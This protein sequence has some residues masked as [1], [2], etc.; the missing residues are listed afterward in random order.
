M[1]KTGL[2]GLSTSKGSFISGAIRWFRR[3]FIEGDFIPS[4]AFLT[5]G[6]IHGEIIIAESTDPKLRIYPLCNYVANKNK[7]FELW[8][9]VD[10]DDGLKIEALKKLIRLSGKSYGYKQFLGYA[11][12]TIATKLGLKKPSNPVD[13]EGEIVCSE[14]DFLYLQDIGY[15]EKE[16]MSM[17]KNDV[18]PDN[19]L[20][21]L[22]KSQ[23]AKLRA[24]SEYGTIE[25]KWLE[26]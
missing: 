9:I 12:I 13:D 25:L 2:I 23:R 26:D 15:D 1:S 6:E 16:L 10:V 5:F 21:S 22:R 19:I 4:H 14:Y 11:W 7:R 8:E 20:K 3:D 17:D 24:V 18:A